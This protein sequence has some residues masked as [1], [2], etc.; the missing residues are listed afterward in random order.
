MDSYTMSPKYESGAQEKKRKRNEIVLIESQARDIDKYF[1]SNNVN[2][3]NEDEVEIQHAHVNEVDDKNEE[4]NQPVYINEVDDKEEDDCFSLNLDD[5][6][7]WKIVDQRTRDYLVKMGPKRVDDISFPKD[8][9]NK[10]FDSSQ[11]KR[12]LPNG[13]TIDR[14]WLV[15]SVSMDKIFCFC[16]KLFKTQKNVTTVGQLG[17]DGFKDWHNLHQSIKSHERN[18]EHLHCMTRWIELENRL[19]TKTTIDKSVELLI[20]SEREH[21]RYVLTR[22]IAIVKRLA[23]NT[24]PFRGDDERLYVENNGLFLQ[25][26]EMVS[27]FDPVM[28][29]HLQRAKAREIQYMYLDKKIQNELIQ[30]LANEVRSSIVKKVKHAKYFAVILGCTLDANQEEQMFLIVRF[31]DDSATLPTVE[32]HWLEFLKVDNTTELGLATE[33]EKV[34]IKLDLDIDDIRGQGYD[35]VS[36]VSGKH[37]GVQRR[38]CEMN[39]RAF[40]TPCGAQSLN[41]ALCDMANCC[42]KAVSFF[43]VIKRIYTLFSSSTK[44]WKIFKDNVQGLTVNPLSQTCWESDVESVKPIIEQTAQIRDALLD[45][46]ESNEY[47]KVKSE[48][49]SLATY[50][51]QNFEFL[52]GMVIWYKLLHA[53]NI[54]SKFLQTE[55]M[56]INHAIDLLQGLISFLEDY[57][58]IGFAIAMDEATKKTNEMGI[59][60]VFTEKRIIQR[61]RQFDESVSDEVKQSAEESFRVEYFVFIIDQ[62]LSSLR[63]RFEQFKQ[64]DDTFG[65]LFNLKRLRGATSSNLLNFCMNLEK[66]LEHNGRSDINGDNLCSELQVLRCC[67]PSE[68]TKAIEVLQY[69]KTLNVCFPNAYIA[70]KILLTIPITVASTG[71]SFSKLKLIKTYLRSTT[72]QERLNGLTILSI[73]K[74]MVEQLDYSDLIDVFAFKIAR[75]I[76]FN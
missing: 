44:R 35:S 46:A 3:L 32:E 9:T 57:K 73:E 39:P 7:N 19:R 25:M 37:K 76:V 31:V 72:S 66:Y 15:Y 11:Y 50:E 45:L 54:V 18:E 71:R 65:F 13:E 60:A 47:P 61:K 5:P 1:K 24:L 75:Q 63:T 34:L 49:E 69:L 38:V 40:Y 74:E 64:Y 59:E 56:D 12:L 23:K 68:A 21:W 22:I 4:V 33:L 55:S 42:S 17:N 26:V 53:V 10:H 41:L 67:I 43:G 27:E 29:E 36:N 48:A 58:E 8:C 70:Y 28:Q 62:A 16:C 51:L 30:L 20:D 6:G 14:R 52:L 2:A